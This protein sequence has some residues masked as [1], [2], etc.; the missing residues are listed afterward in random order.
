MNWDQI[1]I[2]PSMKKMENK[3]VLCMEIKTLSKSVLLQ[4]SYSF[5]SGAL[6][7]F[8]SSNEI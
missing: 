5:L 2:P 1:W 4:I 8:H 7:I 6:N 3:V